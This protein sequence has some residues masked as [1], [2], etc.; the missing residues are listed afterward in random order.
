MGVLFVE[1]VYMID[2]KYDKLKLNSRQTADPHTYKTFEV[3]SF[4][5]VILLNALFVIIMK[6]KIIFVG[7]LIIYINLVSGMQA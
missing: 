6:H 3:T 2:C 5:H 4:Q 7:F 1:S